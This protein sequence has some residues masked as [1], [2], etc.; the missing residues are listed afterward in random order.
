MIRKATTSD[1]EKLIPLAIEALRI[2][3]Y[4]SLV[5]S[6]DRI[7]SMIIE[8]V[9]SAQ[10]FA[11]V[12]E[13]NGELMGAVGAITV[14]GFWFERYEASVV[15]FY[16]KSPGEGMAMLRELLQWFRSRQALK[17]LTFTCEI[18]ADPRIG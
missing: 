14:P 9:S 3:R 11:R 17:R 6:K 18:D 13:R 15:M 12:C 7:R 1:I 2:E 5:V 4:P 16:C 8:A 10:N